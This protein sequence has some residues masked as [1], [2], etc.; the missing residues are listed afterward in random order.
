MTFEEDLVLL[1]K[2]VEAEKENGNKE[3]K[4][5]SSVIL[6]TFRGMLRI[7]G[8]NKDLRK[9]C[10]EYINGVVNRIKKTINSLPDK[11]HD[12]W[13]DIIVQGLNAALKGD[14]PKICFPPPDP[15]SNKDREQD[16]INHMG[17]FKKYYEKGVDF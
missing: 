4:A 5:P 7:N 11:N 2:A 15:D 14:F 10:S 6:L 16:A 8:S 1:T 17:N 9:L 12:D 13:C 3:D